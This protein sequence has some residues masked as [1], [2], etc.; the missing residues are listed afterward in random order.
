MGKIVDISGKRFGKLVAIKRVGSKNKRSMWLCDCDCG[1]SSVVAYGHLSSGHT[2]SCGNCKY[3]DL[4]GMHFGKW[5]VL[6]LSD[7]KYISPQGHTDLMWVCECSCSKHT[8]KEIRGSILKS[9][10]SKSCGCLFENEYDLTG[11]Y[12]IGYTNNKEPFYFDLEDYDK[13]KGYTWHR[14]KDDYIVANCNINGKNTTIKMHRIVMD[15]LD[16][17]TVCVDHKNHINYDNRKTELRIATN[18]Q[19]SMNTIMPKNN[20]SGYKGVSWNKEKQ[21]W[22]VYITINR[23]RKH[24]G[25]YNDFEDAKMARK[26]AEEKYFGEYSYNNSMKEI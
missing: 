11:E 25:Y 4:T 15:V 16:D 26:K 1:R 10:G 8:I 2:K 9:G 14:D 21:K 19:N 23:N 12:G 6:G 22:E 20:T 3:E 17:N 24:L 7:N 13:I 18:M 5:T